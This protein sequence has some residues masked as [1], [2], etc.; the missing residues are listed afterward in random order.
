MHTDDGRCRKENYRIGT[1]QGA[2]KTRLARIKYVYIQ[3]YVLY[4]IRKPSCRRRPKL[5]AVDI[6]RG[7][8]QLSCPSER[9]LTLPTIFYDNIIYWYLATDKFITET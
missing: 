9:A 8:R 3:N 5:I 2:G 7:W 1:R 6:R 4:I